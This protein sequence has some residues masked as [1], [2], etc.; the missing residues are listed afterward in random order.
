MKQIDIINTPDMKQIDIINT[1]DMKQ[2]DIINTP[3]MKQIDI[4]NTPDMKPATLF[5]PVL[6][7]S[8]FSFLMVF[9]SGVVAE[10][11]I[12]LL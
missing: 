5:L 12:M 7:T 6:I 4:I 10:L 2:I 3:D 9:D 11:I 1:P 8:S